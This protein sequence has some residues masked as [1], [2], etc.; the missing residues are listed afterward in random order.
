M[1]KFLTFASEISS[2][3]GKMLLKHFREK[4]YFK[5]GTSKE[6]KSFF[7]TKADKMITNALKKTFPS[8]SY[9]SEETGLTKKDSNY[10]WII[11]P[12][13]GTSNYVNANPFFSISISLWINNKPYLGIIEAPMLKETFITSIT[14]GAWFKDNL[15][16]KKKKAKT[17]LV[18]KLGSS[19][20][21]YCE[22][23]QLNKN[24]SL[25][26]INQFYPKVKDL[27]KFGSAA[28]EL[29]YVGIGRA[30]VYIAPKTRIWDI[31]AGILF[32]HQANGILTDFNIKKYKWAEF[33]NKKYLNLIAS[34]GKLKIPKINH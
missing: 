16:N 11:D 21:L 7:D 1:D 34:N 18:N 2:E 3:T 30:E 6:I 12:I 10:L 26:T 28:L 5:R 27:R 32:V 15:L 33:L 23:G 9:L 13:D 8:H 29:A 14:K 22:G 19:Y 24:K 25:K 4:N 20:G 17:S 31:A